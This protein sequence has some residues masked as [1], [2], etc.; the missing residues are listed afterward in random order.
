MCVSGS[1]M[2]VTTNSHDLLLS[3]TKS[4]GQALGNAR[5][6]YVWSQ[7]STAPHLC[8][9]PGAERGK[10]DWVILQIG[11][12]RLRDAWNHKLQRAWDKPAPKTLVYH[13]YVLSM[14]SLWLWGPKGNEIKAKTWV[15]GEWSQSGNKLCSF[16]SLFLRQLVLGVYLA[17]SCIRALYLKNKKALEMVLIQQ[18]PI[19][20]AG[21]LL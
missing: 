21:S 16:L 19:S 12:P 8:N 7:I 13:L 17:L 14:S 3:I 15:K 20:S 1:K 10:G 11:N 9:I 2:W 18:S 6:L 5:H 4:P